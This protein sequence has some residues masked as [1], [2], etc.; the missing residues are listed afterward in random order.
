M[1]MQGIKVHCCGGSGESQTG[2]FQM[3]GGFGTNHVNKPFQVRLEL[4]CN[5]TANTK[6]RHLFCF[7]GI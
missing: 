6:R 1:Q 4:P 2:A 5:Y 7:L 3:R